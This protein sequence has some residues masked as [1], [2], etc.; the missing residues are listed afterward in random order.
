MSERIDFSIDK[1]VHEIHINLKDH[2][3]DCKHHWII[4]T[5][6]GRTSMGTCANCGTQRTF[7][8]FIEDALRSDIKNRPYDLNQFRDLI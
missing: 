8:N 4:E 6:K 3:P 1:P 5:P 7:S 2:N